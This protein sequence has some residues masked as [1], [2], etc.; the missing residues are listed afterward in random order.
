MPFSFEDVYNWLSP[1]EAEAAPLE[2]VAKEAYRASLKAGGRRLWH[3]TEPEA[4]EELVKAGVKNP[5]VRGGTWEPWK[6]AGI[7]FAPKLREAAALSDLRDITLKEALAGRSADYF[8]ESPTAVVR[9]VLKSNKVLEVDE[10]ELARLYDRFAIKGGFTPEKAEQE[11]SRVLGRKYDAVVLK[12]VDG[13]AGYTEVI[14]TN[15]KAVKL[16]YKNLKWPIIAGATT[17]GALLGGAPK[18]QAQPTNPEDAQ[19]NFERVMSNPISSM[20]SAQSNFEARVAA[21]EKATDIDAAQANFERAVQVAPTMPEPGVGEPTAEEPGLEKPWFDP[22]D[23]VTMIVGGGLGAK[24]TQLA[25]EKYAPKIVG[26]GKAV[27][28]SMGAGAVYEA[29]RAAMGKP[30]EGLGIT[31]APGEETLLWGAFPVAGKAALKGLKVAGGATG[32]VLKGVDYA[33]H[34][35]VERLGQK[36][37]PVGEW[38]WDNVV[39]PPVSTRLPLAGKSVREMF[40]PGVERLAQSKVLKERMAAGT[41]RKTEAMK[42]LTTDVGRALSREMEGLLPSEQYEVLKGLRGTAYS[43]L[44]SPKAKDLLMRFE[45]RVDES[46]LDFLYENKFRESLAKG[47]TKPVEDIEGSVTPEAITNF[48]KLH[49]A[50]LP[51]NYKITDVHDMMREIIYNPSVSDEMKT[52]VKDMWSTPART[53]AEV[54]DA[55]REA[56]TSYM[57]DKLIAN[58]GLVSNVMKPGYIQSKWGKFAGKYVPRDVEFQLQ[59]MSKIPLIA[60]G[61]YQK[62]FLTPW[63][64][65]K[66]LTRP[67]Y[68]ARNLISNLILNDWGGLPFYRVDVYKEAL[69]DLK[70]KGPWWKELRPLIGGEEASLGQS[71][72]Y[73]LEAGV[74]YGATMFDKAYNVFEKIIRPPTSL[75]RAEE[76]WFKLAKHIHNRTELG[77]KPM[78]SALD[79]QKTIFNYSEVTTETAYLRK[80][81]MPFATWYTKSLPFM[82]ETAVKHPL[83]FGK[84]LAFGAALQQH[85]L[86]AVG[87]TDD[88]WGEIEKTLPNYLQQG[89]YLMMPWRDEQNRLNLLNL[90]YI[91]PGIGDINELWNQFGPGSGG[92]LQIPN[93]VVSILATLQSKKKYSGAPLYFDWEPGATKAA[94][95]FAYIWEQLSPAIV[96][97]GTDWNLMWRALTE[98]EGAPS[99]EAAFGSWLGFKL[100]PVDPAEMA[101][102]TDAIRKIHESEMSMQMQRELRNAKTGEE[103]NRILEKYRKIRESIVAP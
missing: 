75:Q 29:A 20:D 55:A 59:A 93:P 82:V 58:R 86:D 26:L 72:I 74:K 94:K 8:I 51:K 88:E 81:G 52:F 4:A 44:K 87:L 83:R 9:G 32:K 31:G 53:V 37:E 27:L 77:M 30:A 18:A 33:L 48:L 39:L 19:A 12:N 97:G 98:E 43:E 73:Q 92:G 84:W 100:T 45:G 50:K 13:R 14:A 91:L 99:P 24:A 69:K 95:T 36:M 56:G 102:R 61:V 63:K 2:G 17:A 54:A 15:P 60:R 96:P 49:E 11:W 1:K 7:Y 41:I 76:N 5:R 3:L 23:L 67:A 6:P 21:R 34:K 10:E 79:V 89:I 62:W 101:R 22:V 80:Y 90:T 64:V 70:N 40:Q 57:T 16:F 66:T 65:S 25:L 42:S 68:H 103:T 85:G 78:E 46:N 38:L 71:D 35:P 28:E 47:L